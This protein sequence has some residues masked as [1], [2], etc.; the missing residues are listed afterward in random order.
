MI[1]L[2]AIILMAFL[3]GVALSQG[4]ASLVADSVT[5]NDEKQL[6]ATGNIEVFYQ[7]DRLRAAQIT[8][9][10][11]SDRLTI[12]GPIVI[13]AADGTILTANSATL[14]P[15]LRNGILQG[16]RLVLD[17]QLQVAANQIDRQQGRYTQL[18]RTTASSCNVC[19]GQAPLWSIRA[20]KVV[21]DQIEKQLYFEN[22]TFLIRNIPVFWVPRM[23][24]PDPTLERSAGLLIPQQ[25]NTTQ[26]GAGIKLP[27]FIPLGDHADV[28][29]TPY[30]ALE[31]RTLELIYR[32]AFANGDLRI[33]GAV[34]DDTLV[35]DNRSYLFAN[36]SFQF[37]DSYQ[38]Q[39]DIEATSDPAYLLDYGYSDKDRLDSA[40]SI[41]R[42]T[43][44]TMLQA[45][46]TYYQTLRDDE[47]NASLP[48]I[49]A[50]LSYE[51]RVRPAF[52]G[53]LRYKTD[54]DTAYRYSNQDGDT[55]RDVTRGGVSAMW[56][57][58]WISNDGIIVTAETGLRADIYDIRDDQAFSRQDL[59]V[60]PETGITLRWP[61][62]MI[63]D[64]GTAHLIEPTIQIAASSALGGTPPVE[65][66]T[67]NEL[68][69]GNLFSLSRFVGDDAVETG[70]RGALG[71]T[72]TRI[73]K[74]GTD[75][76]LS[77]GRIYRQ[78]ADTRFTLSSGLD[79]E[80]SDWL[81]AGQLK[82]PDG[83]VLDGRALFDDQ[84]EVNRAAGLLRWQ[85]DEV[86]LSAAYIWQSSDLAEDRPDSL[87]EWSFDGDFKLSDAWSVSMDGR[88][89]VVDDRPVRA[90]LGLEWQNE[91]VTID[92]SV[93][94]RYT[95]SST[96]EP[97]TSYGISGS[98]NGFSSGRSGGGQ[99]ASCRN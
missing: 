71:V 49:V 42:V 61:W 76:T 63:T 9:D 44:D 58:N 47:A 35:E 51:G 31:T 87:S 98:I 85:N 94:R 99:A 84:F 90:G 23:R 3:P 10:Q 40:I 46:L 60:V 4:A 66:S 81:I 27:Y 20:E 57:R 26:L 89:D 37:A 14:D 64:A 28:T 97:T 83:F 73:G 8:Y 77:F 43:Y 24:L 25:R 21:H 52:G 69:Q 54:L 29:L 88:Y 70:L 15:Q 92:V 2:L 79:S 12:T 50:E 32:Q 39:F 80:Q 68:D 91:C 95:S 5:I 55:G 67:R 22:A 62:A 72:W 17:Q 41:L 86:S 78:E 48:P 13:Q 18:Y 7:G 34:S 65:D 56:E 45:N 11:S 30:A 1:R 93:S 33:E 36:G 82:I 19:D 38:L 74:T 96:V 6:I 59:R 75:S 16:A 53:T